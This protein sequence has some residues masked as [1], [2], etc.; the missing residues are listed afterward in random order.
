[1]MTAKQT[2][3]NGRLF[4]TL[5]AVV[6]LATGNSC[7]VPNKTAMTT[8]QP[9][10]GGLT[11]ISIT[12]G[13]I[14]T[15][16]LTNSGA[17]FCWGWSLSGKADDGTANRNSPAEVKG[18]LKFVSL[19]A[20]AGY[21]CGLTTEG[22]A[23][24]GGNSVGQFADA[25][26][27]GGN[28]PEAVPGGLK[29]TSLTAGWGQNC[30]LTSDGAAHCWA[31]GSPPAPVRGD[32]RF[33]SVVAASG[34]ECGLISGGAAYCWGD[35]GRDN[36]AVRSPLPIDGGV[37]FSS[38]AAG[39]RHTCG[40]TSSGAAY[41]WGLNLAGELGNGTT[42]GSGSPVPVT[43]ALTFTSLTAGGHTCGLTSRGAAYCWG[44]N[45]DG[46]LGD[47][48]SSSRMAPVPVTGGLTFSHLAAG[49]THTCGLT[50]DGRAYC[51][52]DNHWGQL[53][54]ATRSNAGLPRPVVVATA[55][56]PSRPVDT[57]LRA[58]LLR[59]EIADQKDREDISAVIARNDTAVLFRFMRADSARTLRLK[60]IIERHGW[61]TPALVG[62]D[63]V[64]AAWIIVQHSPD[65]AWQEQMLPV[66]ERAAAAGD[67]R[68]T[69]VSLLTDR[70][71]VHRGKPQRYG[72]SFS[73]RDG[74]LVADPIED[75][76]GL[77]ARRA[78]LGLPPMSEYARQLGEMYKLP[79]EWPPKPTG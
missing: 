44:R 20:G 41:C 49:F 55:P 30:G 13:T 53:G 76:G 11:F 35:L 22:A 24:W 77:D 56:I 60:Q 43:G 67:I 6:C 54:N 16:G 70:V 32:L 2:L 39:S 59:L 17:A 1:M 71:L 15:C 14:E 65:Y 52:G 48:T 5:G 45:N 74:R 69:D 47:G 51:W 4:V 18:G 7:A 40:L 64:E 63:G 31:N 34:H 78:A 27:P 19:S 57:T 58:E 29:F 23:Y 75:I 73:I 26:I 36:P 72:N 8:P 42:T 66:L 12:A 3:A 21:V 10:T 46:E 79:V 50:P 62:K 9:V 33:T 68:R 28:S 61:P 25:S 38:L 37:T